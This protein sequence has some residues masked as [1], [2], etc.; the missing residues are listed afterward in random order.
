MRYVFCLQR[1]EINFGDSDRNFHPSTSQKR[2]ENTID[3]KQRRTR[4]LSSR[5]P[6]DLRE[7]SQSIKFRSSGPSELI[8]GN[9]PNNDDEVFN[10]NLFI[11]FHNISFL[12]FVIVNIVF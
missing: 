3:R 7:L 11:V 10:T 1:S 12:D 8:W 4:N 9:R 6:D 5:S 2:S